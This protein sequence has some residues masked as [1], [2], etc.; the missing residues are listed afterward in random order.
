MS[1]VLYVLLPGI[2]DV[3][4]GLL[5]AV[6]GRGWGSLSV[7]DNMVAFGFLFF[8][9]ALVAIFWIGWISAGVGALIGGVIG[10]IYRFLG[11]YG[12]A[13]ERSRVERSA[14]C[15]LTRRPI[16]LERELRPSQLIAAN[17]VA[18]VVVIG[19]TFVSVASLQGNSQSM[20]DEVRQQAHAEGK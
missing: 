1:M 7:A 13:A 16:A 9:W 17:L 6:T 14:L 2:L 4:G 18:L 15:I 8:W 10:V 3:G 12:R 19:L 20:N 11:S 5:N